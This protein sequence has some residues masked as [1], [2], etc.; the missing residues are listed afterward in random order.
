MDKKTKTPQQ[1]D[2]HK[3]FKIESRRGVRPPK[4]A[5]EVI[6]I[7]EAASLSRTVPEISAWLDTN[8]PY[9][10]DLEILKEVFNLLRDRGYISRDVH[11]KDCEHLV[12]S[13]HGEVLLH[14]LTELKSL[15]RTY[16]AAAN[17]VANYALY[18]RHSNL[19]IYV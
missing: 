13:P 12:Y 6:A 11:N 1:L 5:N 15:G 16:A 3:R 9:M 19:T 14:T 2:I 7:L 10:F 4:R 8:K 17:T 18:L